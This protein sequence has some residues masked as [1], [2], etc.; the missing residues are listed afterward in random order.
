MI[1]TIRDNVP[2]ITLEGVNIPE[3]RDIWMA[4]EDDDKTMARK[5]LA[6]VYH[7]ASP[8]SSYAK[9]SA[10]EKENEVRRDY[11]GMD[12]WEPS[13]LVKDAIKKYR[14]LNTTEL[15][16]LLD[17]A[18]G[19]ADKLSEYFDNIDFEELNTQGLPKYEASTIINS[20]AKLSS[21]VKSIR[22]LRE[23]V[24]REQEINSE[25]RRGAVTLNIFDE[26][27]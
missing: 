24:K 21:V 2:T 14:R 22:E 16:R 23:Q 15:M 20:L 8:M 9:L 7:M 10:D 18:S 5:E 17:S 13:E 11:I 27:L 12:G 3:F 25:K 4:D 26:D 6:Y 1:F 19:V